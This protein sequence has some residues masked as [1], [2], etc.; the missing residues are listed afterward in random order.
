MDDGDGAT[1]VALARNAPVAQTPVD[2]LVAEVF[3]LEI[4][5]DGVD[6]IFVAEAVVLIGVDANAV[7]YKWKIR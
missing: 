5:G 4:S 2:L 6:G 1:P 7:F 3:G